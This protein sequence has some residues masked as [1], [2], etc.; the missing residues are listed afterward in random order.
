[1]TEPTAEQPPTK[2]DADPSAIGTTPS[3]DHAPSYGSA[4]LGLAKLLGSTPGEL[5]EALRHITKAAAKSIGVARAGIWLFSEDRESIVCACRYDLIADK[6]TSG[7]RIQVAGYPAYFGAL[8]KERA[9]AAHDARTDLRTAEFFDISECGTSILDA[10][11][12]HDGKVAGIVCLD[13]VGDARRWT[14]EEQA[15][16]GS[17]A[18]FVSLAIDAVSRREFR[19]RQ[20]TLEAQLRQ[21]QKMEALGQLAGGVAHDFNNLLTIILGNVELIRRQ[22]GAT[23]DSEAGTRL[24]EI[25]HA[26]QRA[27]SLTRKLLTFSRGQMSNPQVL[28]LAE[29][30][31][32][33]LSLT[34]RLL[35]QDV[36]LE[37][38]WGDDVPSV[39]IDPVQLE[40]V[41]LN[42]AVNARDAMENGGTLTI[43]TERA[44]R[45]PA[46]ADGEREF[47]L[48]TFADTGCGIPAESHDRIF[49]PFFT[50]K[51]VGSGT[52]LGLST[53]HGIVTQAG[54][55]VEVDSAPD[56]GARMRVFLPAARESA[57]SGSESTAAQPDKATVLVCE[58]EDSV[59]EL[60]VL[61]L[62]TH[63]YTVVESTDG[64]SAIEAARTHEGTIDLLLS[65]VAMPERDGPEAAAEIAAMYPALKV[66]Y[67]SGFASAVADIEVREGKTEFLAKPFE[68]RTL[69]DRVETLASA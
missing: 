4:L 31:V 59:R 38:R 16:A 58:D 15:F 9:I 69:L 62:R 18:D 50:T 3:P 67:V 47:A 2:T 44:M 40:Q 35:P 33:S 55:F 56:E 21:S 45:T 53:V 42:L 52:G 65:D 19:L 27:A 26:V 57:D 63:G 8:D 1:M 60:V 68:I 32:D 29:F 5:D 54:G 46:G 43:T 61:A 64:D 17:M 30:A 41:L 11:I 23:R 34:K 37:L 36:E 14:T 6:F 39:R 48:L 10:P 12:R 7:T 24:A 51:R 25:D 22:S 28:Q 20:A 49:E 13:H 66:L